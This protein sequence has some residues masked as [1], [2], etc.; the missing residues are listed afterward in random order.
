[1]R[2]ENA[3]DL[4]AA[5]PAWARFLRRLGLEGLA[6]WTLEAAGPLTVFGAQALYIGEPFLR[7]VLSQTQVSALACLL[8][9]DGEMRSFIAFLREEGKV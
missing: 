8:E 9:N 5:W 1:M 7:P 2:M 4:R 6:V 3:P